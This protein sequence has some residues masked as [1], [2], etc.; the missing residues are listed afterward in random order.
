MSYDYERT[1]T[2]MDFSQ[3]VGKPAEADEAVV[4]AYLALHSFK[5]GLD[6]M[7]AIPADLQPLYRQCMKALDK[8]GDARAATNQLREMMKRFRF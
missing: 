4:K 7:E 6:K 3:V 8:I 2:A 5:F 1:K